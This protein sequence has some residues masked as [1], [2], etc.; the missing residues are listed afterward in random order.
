MWP[1][2]MYASK[3]GLLTLKGVSPGR[4][5]IGP[6]LEILHRSVFMPQNPLKF[7]LSYSHKS[8]MVMVSNVNLIFP[9]P[10]AYE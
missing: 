1:I 5:T 8:S 4:F 2:A 3:R 9:I 6:R 10:A 7:A